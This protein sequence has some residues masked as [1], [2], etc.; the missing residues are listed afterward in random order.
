MGDEEWQG[1]WRS[2]W[3]GGESGGRGPLLFPGTGLLLA[4]HFG[5]ANGQVI[6]HYYLFKDQKKQNDEKKYIFQICYRSSTLRSPQAR[7][8]SSVCQAQIRY[9]LY[10]DVNSCRKKEYF[11]HQAVVPS[12]AGV[13]GFVL[14]L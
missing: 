12:K 10:S 8:Y 6:Q 5:P 9:S 13:T 2:F 1:K 7:A 3:E 14:Q 4:D 11:L